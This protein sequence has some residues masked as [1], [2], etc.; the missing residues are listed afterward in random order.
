MHR[1][2]VKLLPVFGHQAYLFNQAG[3]GMSGYTGWVR[4]ASKN[5]R[6]YGLYVTTT[7]SYIKGMWNDKRHT[8]E[9]VK[10][11]S[12]VTKVGT[13]PAGLIFKYSGLKFAPYEMIISTLILSSFNRARRE[14]KIGQGYK[15]KWI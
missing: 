7:V 8:V 5:L 4:C 2:Y 13:V 10:V 3:A 14:M 12:F 15:A 1:E 9:S 6:N 11:F